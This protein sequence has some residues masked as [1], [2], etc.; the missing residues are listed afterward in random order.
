MQRVLLPVAR[1]SRCV[2][3]G[4]TNVPARLKI[5]TLKATAHRQGLVRIFS[6]NL[7]HSNHVPSFPPLASGLP[8]A[9]SP[10]GLDRIPH[11]SSARGVLRGLDW[12]GTAV[13]AAGGAVAAAGTGFDVL[14][15]VAVGTVTAV[16]GGT[17]RD[18]VIL[19]RAPFWSGAAEDGGEPEYLLIAA[20]AALGAFYAFPLVGEGGWAKD[21]APDAIS[22]GAFA[23][24]GAM[25]GARAGLPMAQSLLCGVMTGTGGG[26][27]RDMILKRPVR[28]F[29]SHKELYASA[30]ASGAAVF[31][32]ASRFGVRSFGARVAL[33]V[34]VTVLARGA[35]VAYGLRL[36][37][38]DAAAHEGAPLQQQQ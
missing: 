16:G 6:T 9:V 38:S 18:L 1:A 24:I 15:A 36:P 3:G 11:F 22:L 30:A 37:T 2:T 29:H 23:V 32:G 31:L 19:A 28:I 35:A 33:G 20:L 4:S 17:M 10:D 13:F 26:V 7:K 12:A 5:C 27:V 34:G 8:A 25:N 21:A 14:G